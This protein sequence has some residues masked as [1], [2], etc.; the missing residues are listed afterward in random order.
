M[1]EEIILV[2]YDQTKSVQLRIKKLIA[3]NESLYSIIQ[4][5]EKEIKNLL[6]ENV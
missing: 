2:P 5:N 3:E 1:N 4:T 6:K